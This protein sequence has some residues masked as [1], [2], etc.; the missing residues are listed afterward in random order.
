MNRFHIVFI[1]VQVAHT[2]LLLKTIFVTTSIIKTSLFYRCSKLCVVLDVNQS[3]IG[4]AV[5]AVISERWPVAAI[6]GLNGSRQL[7]CWIEAGWL[8]HY[9]SIKE[10]CGW[11][12]ARAIAGEGSPNITDKPVPAIST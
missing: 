1:S 11:P 9:S 5:I 12:G 3:Q 7:N 4:W 6:G 2:M 8:L 10:Y